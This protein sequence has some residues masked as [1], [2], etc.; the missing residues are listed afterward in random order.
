MF[1]RREKERIE[2]IRRS[3]GQVR[4][5]NRNVPRKMSPTQSLDTDIHRR[6]EPGFAVRDDVPSQPNTSVNNG[7]SRNY[8]DPLHER[9]ALECGNCVAE[10]RQRKFRAQ[11][12]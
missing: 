4:E 3:E 7:V 10:E 9:T 6:R 12:I 8:D 1:A 11:S 5:H 2:C